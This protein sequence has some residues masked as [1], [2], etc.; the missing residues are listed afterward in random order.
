M[1]IHHNKNNMSKIIITI[2]CAILCLS[3]IS[4]CQKIDEEQRELIDSLNKLINDSYDASS[5]WN[6]YY[7]PRSKKDLV[8]AGLTDYRQYFERARNLILKIDSTLILDYLAYLDSLKHPYEEPCYCYTS[9]DRFFLD[10]KR[11]QR[12]A[13]WTFGRLASLEAIDVLVNSFHIRPELE[14]F[15]LFFNKD[16]NLIEGLL[17]AGP[18]AVSKLIESYDKS[19]SLYGMRGTKAAL[20]KIGDPRGIHILLDKIL[21]EL[22]SENRYVREAAALA[23]SKGDPEEVIPRLIDAIENSNN[24]DYLWHYA[25]ESLSKIRSPKAIGPL[26]KALKSRDPWVRENAMKSL[27][28]MRSVKEAN[29]LLFEALKDENP[30]V[31]LYAVESLGLVNKKEKT[32]GLTRLIRRI[33][34]SL[35]TPKEILYLTQSLK[36]SDKDVRYKAAWALGEIRNR[37]SI[38]A[39][40]ETFNSKD[41]LLREQAVSSIYKIQ[42]LESVSILEKALEDGDKWVRDLARW[43]LSKTDSSYTEILK[44]KTSKSDTTTIPKGTL[45]PGRNLDA[46]L[47]VDVDIS[48]SSINAGK[49]YRCLI[50]PFT[51]ATTGRLYSC[52][53]LRWA[54][55]AIASSNRYPFGQ[56]VFN[57]RDYTMI[58][59]VR[60]DK[61]EEKLWMN[62]V[63]AAGYVGTYR[64]LVKLSP[65]SAQFQTI[66][67][68]FSKLKHRF[69]TEHIY[70]IIFNFGG[71]A[72]D[73]I[74]NPNGATIHIQDVR[75]VRNL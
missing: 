68:N 11:A 9:L 52:T 55:V 67:I 40:I 26:K 7:Y 6:G 63:D 73:E 37:K 54:S 46:Y 50:I 12:W 49:G 47:R 8:E 5:D 57:L 43:A 2:L 22:T 41:P 10:F 69:N 28:N 59:R 30:N 45:I 65:L 35:S 72:W 36:D 19:E 44:T 3:I 18:I 39:L 13:A 71:H 64:G 33:K 14:R 17:E 15:W 42:G 4:N 56:H 29:S 25:G 38:P 31:R 53:G 32:P 75:F 62:F 70:Q 61:G 34:N 23:L 66:I 74:L 58:I 48:T 24:K 51:M 60:G 21:T 16:Y 1:I 27:G 20:M